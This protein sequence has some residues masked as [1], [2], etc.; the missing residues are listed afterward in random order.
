MFAALSP[1]SFMETRSLFKPEVEPMAGKSP[2]ESSDMI[3]PR[4]FEYIN[5]KT[6]FSHMKLGFNLDIANLHPTKPSDVRWR[7]ELNKREAKE[8]QHAITKELMM[9]K[10]MM[11]KDVE[12]EQPQSWVNPLTQCKMNSQ[13]PAVVGAKRTRNQ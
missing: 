10:K 1:R 13:P 7:G 11:P 4:H 3:D 6:S 8:K 2:S 5:D 9:R 12:T